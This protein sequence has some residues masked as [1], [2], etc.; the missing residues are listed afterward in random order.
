VVAA[1]VDGFDVVLVAAGPRVRRRP[2]DARRL[3]A[4]VRERG[5]VLV[6]VGGDLPERSHVRL[7]VESGAWQGL[8]PTGPGRLSARRAE[9]VAG[10]RGEA[11]RPRRAHLWLPS[12]TGRVVAAA[13][14]APAVPIGT[15]R[16]AGADP[17]DAASHRPPPGRAR[18][19]D[20]EAWDDLV[21]TAG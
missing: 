17:R 19:G 7:T 18:P 12:D 11:S 4:R 14:V 3:A 1:L 15:R 21:E 16:R 6:A 13:P 2:A 10:G 20:G 9:V 5:T 8:E